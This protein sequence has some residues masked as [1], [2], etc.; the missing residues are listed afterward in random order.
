MTTAVLL[1]MP[2][3]SWLVTF[4]FWVAGIV[5]VL[6]MMRIGNVF[7]YIPNNQVGIVEKMWAWKGSIKSGFIALHG[8][9]GFQ[10]EILRGG[11]HVFF[12]FMYRLHKSDLVT[13]GQGKI[14]YPA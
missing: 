2:Y 7:R 11:V 8:E 1:N 6:V 4:G 14:A 13:V 5:T 9:A 10:P 3:M 12:P